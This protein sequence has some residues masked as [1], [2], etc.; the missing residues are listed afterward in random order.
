MFKK[1]RIESIKRVFR[2]SKVFI[3]LSIIILL[4]FAREG[5]ITLRGPI[6][7]T[8]LEVD[9]LEKRFVNVTANAAYGVFRYD[10][11]Y[12]GQFAL[13][14]I[15]LVDGIDK[16]IG[17]KVPEAKATEFVNLKNDTEKAI[18]QGK[19]II[20]HPIKLTGVID[21][22]SEEQK[23]V[24]LKFIKDSEFNTHVNGKS[25]D[26]ILTI[27]EKPYGQ[28]YVR[29]AIFGGAMLSG[30]ILCHILGVFGFYQILVKLFLKKKNH[31]ERKEIETDYLN[32]ETFS[33]EIR[34]GKKYSFLYI[35]PISV[36]LENK[37]I[38][39]VYSQ[40]LRFEISKTIKKQEVFIQ[41][42]DNRKYKSV[43]DG[44]GKILTYY[45]EHFPHIEVDMSQDRNLSTFS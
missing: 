29:W 24:Y 3:I 44:S 28:G 10:S 45:K 26:Y 6:D 43:I 20:D 1:M 17:V 5:F 36:I 31:E 13:D 23:T 34:I 38:S 27:T 12:V 7:I 4:L 22:M 2:Y 14:Y 16:C 39:S 15:I 11:I 8:S 40:N 41:T 19:T 30:V 37:D 21:K 42:T 35:G 33:G 9:D 32:A 25:I 18:N